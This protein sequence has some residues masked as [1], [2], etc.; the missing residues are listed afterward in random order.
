MTAQ[1]PGGTTDRAVATGPVRIGALEIASALGQL[2]PTQEQ[3]AVIEAPLEPT[4]VVAGA[5]SGKT[6]TMAS[7]VVWLV[8]NDI[9]RPE[10]V[11]GLTFTRKAA[12]ELGDRIMRRLRTATDRGL[13]APEGGEE[14]PLPVVSTYHAYAGRLVSEHGLRWGIEP[15][16]R[17]L[18]EASA[19]QLAHEV[20]HTTDADLTGF[21]KA[22]STLVD[23]VLSLSGELAEHLVEA[24]AARELVERYAARV[25]S[26]PGRDHRA[27]SAI[28][29]KTVHEL[30]DQ[31]R[32]YP[33]VERYQELKR[34]RGVLDF[35]D[36]MAVAARLARSLPAVGAQERQ[37]H[38]AVLLDEFQDTSEAQ[39][40]LLSS[41]FAGQRMPLTAVG[42]PSQSIY[43]W[44]G[45]S[46]TTLTSFPTA[47][48]VRRQ[49]LGVGDA[50]ERP[51]Q[52]L[53]LSTSWRNAQRILTVANNVS[54]T[55]RRR[56]EVHVAKLRPRP[57]ADEGRV[58]AARLLTHRDEADYVARW[59]RS[60]WLDEQVRPTGVS[61]AV[62]C[63]N[64]AQFDGIVQ[65]LRDHG[66]P[67][68]VVGL[69][70][71]LSA[72][73]VADLVA[74]LTVAQ[75]PTR[76]DALMRLLT[77]PVCRLGP[78][79]IDGLWAWV[80]F[81]GER[82]G[83][84]R[85]E[86]VLSDALDR[87]PP[88]TW[89]GSRSR[90]VSET[91]RQRV[92]ALGQAVQR[93]RTLAGLPLPELLVEAERSIGLDLEVTSDPDLPPSWGRA[94][95]DALAEVAATFAVTAERPTLGGFVDWLEAA[96]QRER[97]LEMAE[98]AVSDSAVQVL[99]V[100]AA[101]GLE[102]DVVAVPGLAEGT[103]PSYTTRT[104][105]TETGWKADVPG[106]GGWL[107]G[108][109]K[110]P[111]PLRGDAAGLPS[112]PLDSVPDTHEL[113]EEIASFRAAGGAHQLLEE[114]RL[115]YVAFTRAR[116]E[117]LVTTPVWST[118]QTPRE[119]SRFLTELIASPEGEVL[120]DQW[121]PMPDIDDPAQ[122]R[123]P[124]L[125]EEQLAPW[126]TL[127]DARRRVFIDVVQAVLDARR[128]GVLPEPHPDDP[129]SQEVEQ[130]LRER[131]ETRAA[132]GGLVTVDLP[133]HLS[134]SGLVE[135]TKDRA[136]YLQKLRRPVP[137][138]PAH[139]AR[140]GTSFHAWVERY[141]GMPSLVDLG[142]LLTEG[143]PEPE[144]VDLSAMRANFMASEWA[145]RVPVDVEVSVETVIGGKPIRGRIDAVFAEVDSAS[146]SGFVIVD[147]KTGSPG[148]PEQAA[149]R[150]LQLAVYQVAYARL[151]GVDA[152]RVSAA[153]FYAA[154]GETVRPQLP[155]EGELDEV[156]S[157][158]T[159][160]H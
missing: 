85:G 82:A 5:G 149:T 154:T 6:E 9:V 113:D 124:L 23:A 8:V 105:A 66:L 62:L 26:L 116:H 153:F 103:F 119:T 64:R 130:L 16:S 15:D 92:H 109:G 28:G 44:R 111:Y 81:L 94:Q 30:R 45:A 52:V 2:P 46:A 97:G 38:R 93:V 133:A 84:G 17:L 126:P 91:A 71:L 29:A 145:G 134:T 117:L 19:W 25:A 99:T 54:S 4:L 118:G 10:E 89:V 115:A 157:E 90:R 77:G 158:V 14:L 20:V 125:A 122:T 135:L 78:A 120:L 33:L 87:L 79:D 75:D 142:D 49:Q 74:L 106:D 55:L 108:I 104:R 146:R 143:E 61:A 160:G 18:S 11:L 139:A 127:P 47:F 76:G 48:P 57:G 151:R 36:Q 13:W 128:T 53:P 156:V 95:L 51:A 37:L 83:T 100:H 31:A 73:E 22:P 24:N 101:K 132:R 88:S 136:A 141:Y 42:D 147:W 72:P 110:L 68:E 114:R 121:E 27:P 69:G 80:Q 137:Q 98:V 65:A 43:G 34:E 21:E 148:G 50:D 35:A 138:P 1:T 86:A 102:W 40:V 59:V 56:S 150:L 70:G 63:R 152:K 144:P 96:R 123:N 159:T 60:H 39:M 155:G 32:V 41:L 131:D 107:T 129:V 58:Q 3:V 12:I 7:R 112:L 140:A 67:V